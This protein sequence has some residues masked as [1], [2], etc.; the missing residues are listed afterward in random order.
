LERELFIRYIIVLILLPISLFSARVSNDY[1]QKGL[2]LETYLQRHHISTGI[3]DNLDKDDI[4]LVSEI[5]PNRR[6]YE[7][8]AS[9]GVLLQALIPTGEE[10]QLH[11]FRTPSC[12]EIE[13]I[14]VSYQKDTYVTLLKVEETPHKDIVRKIKNRKL[15]KE[16]TR[17][18]KHSVNFRS[19]YKNDKLAIVYDQKMRFGQPIGIPDIKVA[20]L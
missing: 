6:F 18:M 5:D 13:V 20:M 8:I 7:M 9:N 4:Q 17:V 12:Y 16:F 1:W 15:A 2:D 14:P 10:L 19:I 3:I 11:I